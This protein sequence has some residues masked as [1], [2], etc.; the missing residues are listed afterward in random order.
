VRTTATAEA[1]DH[2]RRGLPGT[3]G[4]GIAVAGAASLFP[5]HR[6]VAAGA[7]GGS[8][9]STPANPPARRRTTPVSPATRPSKLATSS[10]TVVHLEGR[11]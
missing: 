1:I 5:A 7:A 3:I 6:R 4:T 9:D 8:L 11:T 10:S 2:D